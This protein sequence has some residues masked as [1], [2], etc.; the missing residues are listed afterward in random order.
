MSN[1]NCDV[2]IVGAGIIGVA[3]AAEFAG[4][5]L[6]VVIVDGNGIASGATGA[7]MGH[8]VVMDDS[9]A[10]F[11]LTRYS[12]QL[13]QE[14]RPELPAGV[15][16]EQPGTIWIAADEEEMAEVHRKCDYYNER[17]VSAEQL[18][19]RELEKL[20]P[21]LRLGLVGGLRVPGDCVLN[22]SYAAQIGR[23]HV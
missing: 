11:S 10:Q 4:R 2:L 8:I 7:A 15:E 21:N 16:Y 13:W 14:V 1:A 5:G 18:N 20:E 23:A 12:Q 22:P 3:C 6:S 19:S 9:D 17:G